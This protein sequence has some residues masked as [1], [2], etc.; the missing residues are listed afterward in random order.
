M[1][2]Q[3]PN[4]ITLTPLGEQQ[5]PQAQHLNV[6]N[7]E[8]PSVLYLQLPVKKKEENRFC[9]RCSEMEHWR[10]YCQVATWCKFCTSDTHA[11][12]ACQKYEKFVKDN[13]I[14]LSRRNTPVQEQKTVVNT[15]EPNQRPRFPHPPTQHFKPTCDTTNRDEQLEVT[16]G[17]TRIQRTFSKI[18]TDTNKRSTAPNVKTAPSSKKLPRC[19][20]GPMLPE[21]PHYS[22]IH[23]HRPIPQQPIEVNEIGLT[24][25]QGMIQ[26]PV[27]RSTQATGVRPRES[28]PPIKTQQTAERVPRS[29]ITENDATW[30]PERHQRNRLP[31]QE[32]DP[33][34]N[35][36]I[37]NCVHE[38]QTTY[39]ERCSQA[40]VRKPLLCRRSVH[41]SK[42]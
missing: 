13:P 39:I 32:G 20:Y 35:D 30:G 19:S 22:Q 5:V 7:G 14:A 10:H 9:T 36:Y 24:I 21:T 33:N 16:S 17:R 28:A 41:T 31:K 15:Q 23:H 6:F 34:H 42:Q 4:L 40:S 11:T 12:Q 27:Q 29:E 25:Q 38:K 1:S 3:E 18:A 26:C 37:L 8:E 2:Q